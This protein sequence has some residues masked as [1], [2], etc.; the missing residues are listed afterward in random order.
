MTGSLSHLCSR[1]LPSQLCALYCRNTKMNKKHQGTWSLV[2]KMINYDTQLLTAPLGIW[3]CPNRNM[4]SCS[5]RSE[6][7]T[8]LS[9]EGVKKIICR[10][11]RWV[12]LTTGTGGIQG[13]QPFL[14][15]RTISRHKV[16]Q[17][18]AEG[19][20]FCKVCLL[21]PKSC[22]KQKTRLEKLEAIRLVTVYGLNLLSFKT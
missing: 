4:P 8:Q 16:E 15:Q 7:E 6:R 18:R 19:W 1:Y 10:K 21:L 20:W 13:Q 14:P 3:K 12:S 11:W 5:E 17:R 22:A 2:G 9:L